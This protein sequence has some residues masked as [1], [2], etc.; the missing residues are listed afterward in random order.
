MSYTDSPD[1]RPKP[2]V[3][4]ATFSSTELPETQ[5]VT[6]NLAFRQQNPVYAPTPATSVA[7]EED[8]VDLSGDDDETNA[9]TSH[10]YSLPPNNTLANLQHL[11]TGH[12]SA[13]QVD[14]A[15][16]NFTDTPLDDQ[17]QLGQRETRPSHNLTSTPL[18]STES[19]YSSLLNET[20]ISVS[21]SN[22]PPLPP[23]NKQ[24]KRPR[25]EDQSSEET[26]VTS[27]GVQ[28]SDSLTTGSSIQG[29]ASP[30]LTRSAAA[31]LNTGSAAINNKTTPT[32]KNNQLPKLPASPT[33]PKERDMR[34]ST[35]HNPITIPLSL[36]ESGA[37]YKN[38]PK[39]TPSVL[40][41]QLRLQQEENSRLLTALRES[42]SRENHLRQVHVQTTRMASLSI[43]DAPNGTNSIQP[44]D[45]ANEAT[46]RTSTSIPDFN[47]D[48]H[49]TNRQPLFAEVLPEALETW[50]AY[51]SIKHKAAM[52]RIKAGFLRH[53]VSNNRFPKWSASLTPP[54]GFVVSAEGAT[55][56][57]N[58]RRDFATR[59]MHLLAAQLDTKFTTYTQLAANEQE[60]VRTLYSRQPIGADN[61]SLTEALQ[62]ASNLV[63]RDSGL[64]N[65]SL[66]KGVE[67]L[68]LRPDI[69][70]WTGI[71]NE[72][73]PR[74]RRNDRTTRPPAPNPTTTPLMDVQI[75]P[76]DTNQGTGS[77][78]PTQGFP[79]PR[80]RPQAIARSAQQ[81]PPRRY[82][83]R[84]APYS[85]NR[86]N[87]NRPRTST[88]TQAQPDQQGGITLR[89]SES[90]HK[91]L[92]RLLQRNDQNTTTPTQEGS[93]P[94]RR[95]AN[96]RPR[97]QNQQSRRR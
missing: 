33:S 56:L 62:L 81:N 88:T 70:L 11:D 21:H 58:L 52:C 42:Q 19:S 94:P 78:A 18:S 49:A 3:T 26:Q 87:Q 90:E 77:S 6:N 91:N 68:K 50:R 96:N 67:E 80:A 4:S 39:P 15:P 41:A 40:A 35:A 79:Q 51:R 30:A 72:L 97:G 71:P 24:V 86:R 29:T 17:I 38:G 66:N 43:P 53:L 1:P 36:Q 10:S 13:E 46:T 12:S 85:T 61:Y 55:Q 47:Q 74:D 48:L 63:H 73:R 93:R 25:L 95:R 89:V 69:Y 44:M 82:G 23:R 37:E 64:M 16:N 92:L 84:S 59:G 45:H 34:G 32:V 5:D 57:V 65:S 22:N 31:I 8:Y 54:T 2:P 20:I 60:N 14:M 7:D 83:N 28:T 27:A 9:K 76:T 75:Q